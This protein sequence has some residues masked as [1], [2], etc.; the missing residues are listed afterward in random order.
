MK[1]FWARV[2]ILVIIFPLLF[3][4]IF[5][6][7]F[8]HHL[9][10][11][12]LVTAV[13]AAGAFEVSRMFE[14][15]GM[16]VLRRAAP[17]LAATLPAA[18]YLEEIAVLPAG[19]FTFWIAALFGVF[20]T[21]TIVVNKNEA[22]RERLPL[23]ASST[24][25]LFCPAFFLVFIVRITSLAHPQIALLYLLAAVFFNDILAYLSGMIARGKTRL[26]LLVSPNKSLIG[27]IFGFATSVGVT[28]GMTFLF[29]DYF[30]VSVPAAVLL[31]ALLALTAFVGDLFESALKRSCQIK[32]SGVIMAGRGG[33]MDAIDSLLLSAPLFLFLF[34]LIAR[35]AA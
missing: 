29:R 15:K 32:D 13:A 3:L 25:V 10:F 16:A 12:V 2:L 6:V 33:I 35:P 28:V 24:V 27:F 31:G 21:I 30:V 18:A 1:N 22:L 8:L 19:F 5:V 20:F 9:L 4:V 26:N 34:P 17:L 11:N 23:L 7:P 14:K